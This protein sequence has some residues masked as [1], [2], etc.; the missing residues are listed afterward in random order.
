MFEKNYGR[1]I[2]KFVY[3]G[4]SLVNPGMPAVTHSLNALKIAES[5][6]VGV[7]DGQHKIQDVP[8]KL[9]N[10]VDVNR[11]C[12]TFT[13]TAKNSAE[14]LKFKKWYFDLSMIGRHFLVYSES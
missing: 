6:V 11:V 14:L 7:L 8:M 5:L 2:S 1:D 13:F 10:Q 3:G 4:Y 9:T 12:K